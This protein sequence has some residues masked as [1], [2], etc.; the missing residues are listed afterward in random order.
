MKKVIKI[1]KYIKRTHTIIAENKEALFFNNISVFIKDPLPA[2]VPLA[3]VLRKIE[4]I[5][6]RHLVYNVD[7][8]YVGDFEQFGEREINALYRDGALY[9]SN[10]QDDVVDLLDDIVHEISHASEEKYAAEIYGDG[11]LEQEY[12]NKKQ[13]LYE[14]LISYGYNIDYN[15]FMQTEYTQ[16]FDDLLYKQIGYEKLEFYAMGLFISNYA[17]TS[18][19]EYFSVG[20]ERYFLG[21]AAELS[22][23]SPYL[24]QKVDNLANLE[25]QYR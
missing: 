8:V 18:L 12:L 22:G 9:I 3:P 24:Y 16:E 10:K 15:S 14:I 25:N 21:N 6:P 4:S 11:L 5:I 23:I 13:R 2:N 1:H 20:F 7:A 19:R 17:I